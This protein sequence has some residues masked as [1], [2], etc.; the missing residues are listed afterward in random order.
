MSRRILAL[1]M[2]LA[3][4][5]LGSLAVVAY[6][7]AADERAPHFGQATVSDYIRCALWPTA[8]TPLEP[9]VPRAPASNGR[10]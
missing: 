5:A 10:Q 7:R 6:V 9:M 8:P 1:L 2:A 4:A 3:L